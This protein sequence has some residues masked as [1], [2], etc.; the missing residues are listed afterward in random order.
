MEVLKWLRSEGCPWD[1]SACCSAAGRGDL[2]MLKWMRSEGCP[3]DQRICHHAALY[4]HLEVLKWLRSEGCPWDGL[5]WFQA[6]ESVREWMEENECPK[7]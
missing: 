2:E 1:G 5:T 3:W 4:G 6:A 7:R